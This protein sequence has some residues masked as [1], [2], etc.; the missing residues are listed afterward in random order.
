MTIK[1]SSNFREITMGKIAPGTLYRS[2]HPINNDKQVK[3]VI[4]AVNHAKIKTVINLSDSIQS[5]QS[6]IIYCPWY[7]MIYD[8]NYFIALNVSMKFSIMEK[9]FLGKMQDAVVFM[10]ENDPPYLIHCEAGIDRTG[11]L[12]VLLGS[13]MGAQFDD[14]VKDY[15]LSF[16]DNSE[17]SANDRKSGSLFLSNLFSIMKGELLNSNDD[18]QLLAK[19]YLKE[20]VKIKNNTLLVLKNKLSNHFGSITPK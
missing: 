9:E 19:N 16:V 7:K 5:L 14:M 12:S 13:F 18:L 17:Y 20:N 2:S 4:L 3:E 15:M 1:S 11:F 8:K 10:A 6:R